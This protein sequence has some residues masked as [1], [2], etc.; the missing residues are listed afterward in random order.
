MRLGHFI[1]LGRLIRLALQQ[2]P[3]VQLIGMN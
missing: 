3:G 1:R 2:L